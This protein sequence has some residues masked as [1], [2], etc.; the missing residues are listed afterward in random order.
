MT[1]IKVK[2]GV[3]GGKRNRHS[4]RVR[5][6]GLDVSSDCSNA[7]WQVEGSCLLPWAVTVGNSHFPSP[8]S[9]PAALN[10]TPNPT[11]E[12]R[13]CHG[14]ATGIHSSFVLCFHF[15]R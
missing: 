8:P 4:L 12:H 15:A 2:A 7:Q 3:G 6:R 9:T 10:P 13:L 14:E 1:H 11:A 5:T